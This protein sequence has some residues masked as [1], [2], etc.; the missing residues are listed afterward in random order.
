MNAKEALELTQTFNQV[1]PSKE[2]ISIIEKIG[3]RASHGYMDADINYECDE[4]LISLAEL[5]YKIE[6]LK[7]SLI[8]ISWKE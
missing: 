8:R 2:M 1:K 5:G 3:S 6:A 7:D 4:S